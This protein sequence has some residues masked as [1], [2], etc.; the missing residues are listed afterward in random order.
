MRVGLLTSGGPEYEIHPEAVTAANLG[1]ALLEEL[2][3]SVEV[4][5]DDVLFGPESRVN[6]QLWMTRMRRSVASLGE[7]IGRPLTADEVEP[8]NWASAQRAEGVDPAEV[9]RAQ[10]AQQV[11]SAKAC[12]WMDQFD[13]LVTPTSGCP[14][15]RTDELY[16]DTE[17]PWRIG[18]TYGLIGRFTLP[19]NATGHP[20]ISLPLHWT[21]DDLPIGTQ[22]VAGMGRE[23]LLIRLGA[24]LEQVRPWAQ[25]RPNIWAG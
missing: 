19:F 17:K 9:F 14:P 15:M 25:R 6:G 2:G 11:W 1:A 4:V 24:Q 5:S 10:T 23:D 21:D 8:Y 18:R 16:P 20:A 22:F 12:Q 13:L 3:H 7:A